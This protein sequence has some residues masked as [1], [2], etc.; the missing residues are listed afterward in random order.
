MHTEAEL[1]ALHERYMTTRQ[2]SQALGIS[3]ERVGQL[4]EAGRLSAIMFIDTWV[5]LR[6]QVEPL[7]AERD[8]RDPSLLAKLT[9]RR[10]AARQAAITRAASGRSYGY[11]PSPGKCRAEEA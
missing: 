1:E 11:L 3:A 2:V 8:A 7:V 5:F 6:R 4:R 10:E 9:A